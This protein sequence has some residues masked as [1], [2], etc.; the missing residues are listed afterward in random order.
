MDRRVKRVPTQT[1]ERFTGHSATQEGDNGAIGKKKKTTKK[2]KR[3][4]Q[5]N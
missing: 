4:T 2:K 5:K 1:A 3:Y